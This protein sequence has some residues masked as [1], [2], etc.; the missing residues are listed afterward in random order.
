[1]THAAGG[2]YCGPRDG[3]NPYGQCRGP[4]PAASS[5]NEDDTVK[6]YTNNNGDEI[7]QTKDVTVSVAKDGTETI[8]IASHKNI[9]SVPKVQANPT[10]ASECPGEDQLFVKLRIKVD[11]SFD[12]HGSYF[13][14]DDDDDDDDDSGEYWDEDSFDEGQE[15]NE[16]LCLDKFACYQFQ[17][18]GGGDAFDP[19]DTGS[20]KLWVDNGDGTLR[21]LICLNDQNDPNDE[22]DDDSGDPTCPDGEFETAR[23]WFGCDCDLYG[24]YSGGCPGSSDDEDEDAMTFVTPSTCQPGVLCDV[25]DGGVPESAFPLGTCQGDCDDDEDVSSR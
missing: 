17:I 20:A 23:T 4:P 5:F 8:E 14:D 25:G 6:I 22:D 15:I 11:K 2:G 9:A 18:D 7:I 10:K 16:Y 21:R 24:G 12:D 1:M 3:C 13:L 19:D